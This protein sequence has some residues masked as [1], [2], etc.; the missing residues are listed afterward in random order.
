MPV[1]SAVAGFGTL[2]QWN[3]VNLAEI[4]A[5]SGP[6]MKVD[7][8]DVTHYA[9][10]D[11]FREYVVGL[12]DGGEVTIEG[13]FITGDTLGQVAFTT[14]FY[15]LTKREVIITGPTAAAFTLTFDA[16]I[17]AFEPDYAMDGR[18]GFTATLK[19]SSKPV[20]AITASG[21]LTT[22]TGIEENAGAAL[23]FLPAFAAAKKTYNV[24]VNTASTWVKFTPTLAGATITI[25]DGTTTQSVASGAQSGTCTLGAA[26]SITT[27]LLTV[28]ETGK[29][30]N[31]YT[32]HVYRA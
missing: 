27:M 30:G 8:I 24:S 19:V 16:L 26:L 1:T 22:L 6:S 28:K 12:I 25:Y 4:S 3:T 23:T 14:D 21:D 17:T 20:L 15:A 32:V 5:I 11:K 31:T 29:V 2:I 10:P 7:T 13:N 18:L 9:S